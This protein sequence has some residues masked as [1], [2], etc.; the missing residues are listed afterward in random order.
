MLYLYQNEL[1]LEKT[2]LNE[3]IFSSNVFSPSLSRVSHNAVILQNRILYKSR[4]INTDYYY[5]YYIE[6]LEKY[7]KVFNKF[8]QMLGLVFWKPSCSCIMKPL[9]WQ[10]EGSTNTSKP[11][12]PVFLHCTKFNMFKYIIEMHNANKNR[13]DIGETCLFIIS[14]RFYYSHQCFLKYMM[15][16]SWY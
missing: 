1:N 7:S 12:N 5:Y 2:I 9:N 6:F 14:N 13:I 11:L 16:L 10:F 3:T 4:N 15:N 8:Q